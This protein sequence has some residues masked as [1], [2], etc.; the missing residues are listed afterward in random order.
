MDGPVIGIDLGTTFSAVA[1]VEAKRPYIIPNRTGERLTPSLVGFTPTGERVVGERAR[2]LAEEYPESVAFATKRFIGRRW[3]SD[4][5]ASARAV[6][7]YPLV[8]G[9]SGEI[10]IRLAGKVLPITQ[11]SA[12]VL[13]EL[14]LDAE[15]HFKRPVSQAVVTV[16][17]NFDDGQRNATKEAAR[18]AGLEVLRIVNEPTAAA[19]AYGLSSSFQGRALVFDLGGGTFDVSILEVEKGVFQ[20]KA[21][22]GDPYL[23][24]EDFDERIVQWLVAQVPETFRDVVSHDK[25]SMQ[26]LKVAAERAKRELSEVEEAAISVAELGDHTATHR[27]YVELNTAL[28][29]TFFEAL[30]EPLSRRCLNVCE[31]VMADAELEPRSM[32]VV[33]LVGGMTRVPLVRRLVSDFFGKQAAAGVN[34]DEVVALGAAVHA[35]ELSGRSGAALLIDVT[36]HSLGVGV[37]GGKVRRLIGR[38]TPV[39]VA[40]REIFFPGRAGQTEARIPVYQGE[41]DSAE[42]SVKLGEVV[43]HDLTVGKRTDVPIEV[44]FELSSEGTLSVRAMDL[45]TGLAEATRIEART[46]LSQPEVEKLREEQQEYARSESEKLT[47]SVAD[48]LSDLLQRARKLAQNLEVGARENPGPEADATVARVQSL[49]EAAEQAAREKDLGAM[50]E[51]TRTLEGLVGKRKL[52]RSGN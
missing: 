29:R 18:I 27:R 47:D 5:A 30:S 23:G 3:S 15:A 19:V 38:N 37:L 40:A 16:P 24:G 42:A 41:S 34:P 13:G 12:M 33:L 46:E 6:V 11:V 36:A 44:C 7:P 49:I 43:L 14:K 26:R 45:S 4:L 21:T 35:S 9:P 22:G 31:K 25:L 39:P 50:A 48:V 8:S 20:V 52:S 10:R 28:T 2:L 17:A 32:D 51:V 1:S